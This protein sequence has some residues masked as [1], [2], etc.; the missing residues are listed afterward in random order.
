MFPS[1]EE[2]EFV[3]R[4]ARAAGQKNLTKAAAGEM[5][6]TVART[7]CSSIIRRKNGFSAAFARLITIA[8]Y[9]C[10]TARLV[11]QF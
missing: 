4:V 10:Q 11:L 6:K 9:S 3:L 8:L 1:P 7:R 2:P 5:A